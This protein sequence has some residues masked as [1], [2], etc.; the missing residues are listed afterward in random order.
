MKAPRSLLDRHPVQEG[1][2]G[3]LEPGGATDGLRDLGKLPNTS[4]PAP[5]HAVSES[6]WVE[7]L[8]QG[9]NKHSHDDDDLQFTDEKT[10]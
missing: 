6:A 7:D 3:W 8:R 5:P 10:H 9:H 4:L 1:A 2:G